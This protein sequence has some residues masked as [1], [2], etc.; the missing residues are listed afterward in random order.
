MTH[1]DID[2]RDAFFCEV[3]R[4]EASHHVSFIM[5]QKKSQHPA[6]LM[7]HVRARRTRRFRS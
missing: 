1:V 2:D 7:T 3:D 4:E 5:V 6:E